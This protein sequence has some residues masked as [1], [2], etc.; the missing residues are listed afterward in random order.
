M[1]KLINWSRSASMSLK[2]AVAKFN[3]EVQKVSESGIIAPEM[4]DYSKLR[5]NISTQAEYNRTMKAL[6]SFSNPMQ[7]EGVK[8]ASGLEITKWEKAELNKAKKRATR[9]LTGELEGLE[10][11][12]SLGTGNTRINEI[13]DTLD[14]FTRIGKSGETKGQY[15]RRR[16]VLFSQA[17]TDYNM[18]KARI[19]QENFI[20]AYTKMKRKE[21]VKLAKSFDDPM[22]FWEFIKDS[23][24]TDI[25]LRYDVEARNISTCSFKK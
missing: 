9:R 17:R 22:K 10:K 18:F 19:F 12:S 3:A 5:R 11:T 24:L 16:H 21:V 23:G 1:A 25:E 14:M 15:I 20:E 13:R 7:Q 6:K 4:L 8:V 2:W